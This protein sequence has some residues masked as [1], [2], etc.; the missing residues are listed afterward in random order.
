[1]SILT[2]DTLTHKCAHLGTLFAV[3]AVLGVAFQIGHFAEHAVQFG[4]WVWSDRSLPWMST[5]AMWL[6][7]QIGNFVMPMP[8]FCT[9]PKGFEARQMMIA[10]ELLHLIG[11]S[12]FLVTIGSIYYFLPSR[13]V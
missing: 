6:V 9:D 3:V 4:M 8:E 13:M 11:N 10:M 5:A 7:H 2:S 12:I 1:M